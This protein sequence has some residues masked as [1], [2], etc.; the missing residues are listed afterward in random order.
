[1]FPREKVDGNS[2]DRPTKH[3]S[4]SSS[5]VRYWSLLEE[6][7]L[8][9]KLG[10]DTGLGRLCQPIWETPSQGWDTGM[11]SSVSDYSGS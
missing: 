1:M 11:R 10:V 6:N 3:T 5:V 2:W 9:D 8:P 4:I 7:R